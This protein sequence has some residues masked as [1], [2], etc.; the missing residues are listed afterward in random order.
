MNQG[1]LNRLV[2]LATELDKKGSY[3]EASVIDDILYAYAAEIKAQPVNST[4]YQNAAN[5][6]RPKLVKKWKDSGNPGAPW[7]SDWYKGQMA[8]FDKW[9]KS[10][11]LPRWSNVA[12]AP[13]HKTPAGDTF[14]PTVRE[15]TGPT[16]AETSAKLKMKINAEIKTQ[17]AAI[18]K[19][20]NDA[21]KAGKKVV[22]PQ[23]LQKKIN[24]IRSS[25]EA[26]YKQTG[27]TWKPGELPAIPTAKTQPAAKS[28]QPAKQKPRRRQWNQSLLN[29]YKQI[30]NLVPG[31][32]W[33][34]NPTAI[35]K[36]PTVNTIYK[37]MG[38]KPSA[39]ALLVAVQ[40]WKAKQKPQSAKSEHQMKTQQT[41]AD[42]FVGPPAPKQQP[43]KQQWS[44]KPFGPGGKV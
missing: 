39:E 18:L 21:K 32:K 44:D 24:Q 8:A 5:K 4:E 38:G 3:E 29:S 28:P 6:H 36:N 43:A 25:V 40:K 33:T 34:G 22:S 13:K 1:I 12:A 9:F 20:W 26:K 31:A 10:T 14:L 7:N 42:Q 2:S 17:T 11:G 23:E 41:G 35:F 27:A 16:S 37:G 15:Q 19:Q 30:A